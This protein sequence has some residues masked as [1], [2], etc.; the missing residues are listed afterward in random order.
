MTGTGYY[1]VYQSPQRLLEYLA[2]LDEREYPYDFVQVRHC[3]GDNGAPDV[4]FADRVKAWNESHAYPKLVIATTAE[5]FHALEARYGE[6]LPTAQGDFTPYWEDGAASS[7]RETALN[8]ASAERLVQAE[9]LFAMFNPKANPLNRFYRAWRNVVL[10]DEHTWGAHNS[11]SQP[12]HPFV[13]SQWAIKQAF[14]LEADQQSRE[15]IES[16]LT[17]RGEA[18]PSSEATNLI[19]VINTTALSVAEGL[20]VVP[21]ALSTAGDV[22]RAWPNG[23]APLSAQRLRSGELIFRVNTDPYATQRYAITGG[24]AGRAPFEATGAD[25]LSFPA[26]AARGRF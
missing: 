6:Q 22:V 7:A 16:A 21:A 14:A 3:L 8:R 11:I 12:D 25:G 5:M 9:T 26:P 23:G 17:S 24:A 13:Q 10:Y 4:H 1:Q 20:V 15:L 18:A 2:R 19:D